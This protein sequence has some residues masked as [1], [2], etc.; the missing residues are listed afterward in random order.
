MEIENQNNSEF[1]VVGL[2]MEILS[3][4]Y[5]FFLILWG[6]IISF[7]SGSNS[8]TSYIP[9]ILGIPI[10]VFSYLSIKFAS[11]KKMFMH[12]VVLF[13]LIIFLGGLDFIRSVI[14]GNAFSNLWA[15]LSKIMMLLTGLFFTY[16][17]IKSFIH[18]RKI[19]E[20]GNSD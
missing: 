17:C 1:K 18:A 9:S 4:Y 3:I 19:R 13:G 12:I 11:K 2:T 6:I 14:S 15:D 5:G 20:L 8:M 7:I 10:L 16:Q